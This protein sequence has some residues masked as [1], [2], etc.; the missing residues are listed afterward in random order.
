[1]VADSVLSR[2]VRKGLHVPVEDLCGDGSDAGAFSR[3]FSLPLI[4]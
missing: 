2:T 3:R 4:S 1:M